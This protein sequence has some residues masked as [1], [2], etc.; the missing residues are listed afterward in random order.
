[1]TEDELAYVRNWTNRFEVGERFT[2]QRWKQVHKADKNAPAA[3]VIGG[4][5]VHS[6]EADLPD[7][8]LD[9]IGLTDGP[10][11]GGELG[12]KTGN[13]AQWYVRIK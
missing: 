1:M 7:A 6:L 2:F 8:R 9:F 13:N 4:K 3:T 12:P 5:V 11:K 10:T